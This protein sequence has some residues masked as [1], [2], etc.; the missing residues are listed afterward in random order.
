[1]TGPRDVPTSIKVGM[2]RS[3][4]KGVKKAEGT[5]QDDGKVPEIP[6]GHNG[7]G[8]NDSFIEYQP[9]QGHDANNNQRYDVAL[10]PFSSRGSSKREG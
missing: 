8:R 4:S 7:V 1:M 9:G 3:K 5:T 2:R 10:F 6:R